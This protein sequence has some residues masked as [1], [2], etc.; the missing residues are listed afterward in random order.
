MATCDKNLF[1]FTEYDGKCDFFGGQPALSQTA[2]WV[3]VAGFGAVFSVFTTL[4]V[5]LDHKY[6]GT[7]STSE[8]YNSAGRSIKV[9]LTACDIVSKWTWAAT[10]LQ[11]SNVAYKFGV[12][13]PFW[14]ASGTSTLPPSRSPPRSAFRRAPWRGAY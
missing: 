3:I 14:Y 1:G 13:G 8:Q 7:E 9:G 11:S 2:G 5:W 10:L 12:S 6:G 4:L